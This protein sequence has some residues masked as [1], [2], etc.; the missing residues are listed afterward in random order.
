MDLSQA[1]RTFILS[2]EV[3]YICLLYGISEENFLSLDRFHFYHSPKDHRVERVFFAVTSTSVAKDLLPMGRS[4]R[5]GI[6]AENHLMHAC[7]TEGI[8]SCLQPCL[9]FLLSIWRK[10]VE[11]ALHMSVAPSYAKL[12]G[13]PSSVTVIHH[14]SQRLILLLK[15]LYLLCF[16]KNETVHLSLFSWE[17]LV[18]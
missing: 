2:L 11:R 14:F 15:H 13:Q 8:H 10:P 16:E 1:Q 9:I 17:R 6:V 4:S 7:A 3:V 18:T 12:I 5:A